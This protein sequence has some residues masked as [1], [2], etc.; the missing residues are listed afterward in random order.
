MRLLLF[1]KERI[2]FRRKNANIDIA[3]GNPPPKGRGGANKFSYKST[4][5]LIIIKNNGQKSK[6]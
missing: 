6:F 3:K 2:N 1:N 5:L 4:D